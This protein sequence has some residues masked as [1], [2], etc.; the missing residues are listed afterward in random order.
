MNEIKLI[1]VWEARGLIDTSNDRGGS[2]SLGYFLD[3]ESAVLM[4]KGRGYWGSDE[5]PIER[6]MATTDGISGYVITD[7]T[8]I[9]VNK[10]V[11]EA[12]RKLALAK[13]T[14]ADKKLLG[15]VD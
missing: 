7:I 2:C 12:H 4:G 8:K 1:T 11:N 10:D 9:T 5:L 15:L 6:R 13:L 14:E 3:K